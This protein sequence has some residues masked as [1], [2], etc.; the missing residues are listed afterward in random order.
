MLSSENQQGHA[1]SLVVVVVTVL[2]VITVGLVQ[3]GA[4]AAD[5]ARARNAADAA[6]LAAA[7]GG[8]DAGRRLAAANHATVVSIASDGDVVRVTVRVGAMSATAAA[9]LVDA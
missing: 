1:L 4:R 5:Q 2:M 7:S 3:L 8:L 9:T 6:A